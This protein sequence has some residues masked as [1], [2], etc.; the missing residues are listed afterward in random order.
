MISLQDTE[1]GVCAKVRIQIL[2]KLVLTRSAF[3]ARL[4]LENGETEQLTNIAVELIISDHS[5]QSRA[6]DMF[7]IGNYKPTLKVNVI[8]GW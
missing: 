2:Q 5:T 7:S 1:E 3:S 8:Q 4:E 6:N